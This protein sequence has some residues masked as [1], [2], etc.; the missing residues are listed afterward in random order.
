MGGAR[1]HGARESH[2]LQ[3]MPSTAWRTRSAGNF[4]QKMPEMRTRNSGKLSVLSIQ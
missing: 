4:L 2:F 1:G 3:K